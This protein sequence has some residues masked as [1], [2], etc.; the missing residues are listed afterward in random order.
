MLRQNKIYVVVIS[1]FII[2]LVVFLF[3]MKVNI[4]GN[5]IL[6]ES[7]FSTSLSLGHIAG[8]NV[9][10]DALSFGTITLGSVAH[11]NDL[12]ITNDYGFPIKVEFSV[13]G[14][15]EDLLIFDRVMYLEPGET[16]NF[17]LS[18]I[19]FSDEPYGDYSGKVYVVIRRKI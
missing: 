6:Q 13:E 16:S 18:T 7:E 10:E 3:S 8:F 17:N 19:I 9:S 12:V 11:R 15:I 14:D 4:T 2:S 5:T 1:L